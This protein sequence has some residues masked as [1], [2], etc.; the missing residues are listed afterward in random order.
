MALPHYKL[1]TNPMPEA[2]VAF[3]V[4][5]APAE[6]P[7]RF[8]V[9]QRALR[10]RSLLI[11]IEILA[12]A[13]GAALLWLWLD[14]TIKAPQPIYVLIPAL[15]LGV[16]FFVLILMA[17]A[18]N[19]AD[20]TEQEATPELSL[21]VPQPIAPVAQRQQALRTATNKPEWTLEQWTSQPFVEVLDEAVMAEVLNDDFVAPDHLVLSVKVTE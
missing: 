1:Q 12:I 5:L 20:T 9:I 16:C 3:P 2:R 10:S 6:P 17:L 19:N 4:L 15:S 14:P 11:A 8:A 18:K 7:L 13:A 21:P